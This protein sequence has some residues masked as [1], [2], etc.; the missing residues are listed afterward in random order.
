M[1]QWTRATTTL[2]DDEFEGCSRKVLVCRQRRLYEEQPDIF[3]A[4]YDY[5]RQ[6]WRNNFGDLDNVVYWMPLPEPPKEW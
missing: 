1:E 5:E 3:I 4:W 6:Q 2:P